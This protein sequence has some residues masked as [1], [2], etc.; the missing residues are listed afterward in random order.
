MLCL[1]QQP[2]VETRRRRGD[3]KWKG[4]VNEKFETGM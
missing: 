2:A 3:D 4:E 1:D